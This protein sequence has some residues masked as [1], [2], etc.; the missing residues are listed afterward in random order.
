[1]NPAPTAE[2]PPAPRWST[3]Y[4][5][6]TD[7]AL[8]LPDLTGRVVLVAAFQMLCPA[9]V[10]RTIPQLELARSVF[11]AQDVAVIGLH[12]VF[13]HHRAM[14]AES[15]T[16][17]VHEYGITFPVGVDA[18][19]VDAEG[20]GDPVPLTMRRYGMRGTPTLLLIDRAGRLRRHV[21]GH[22]PDLR[23]GAEVAALVG[24]ARTANGGT[25][26]PVAAAGA[27]TATGVGSG[28]QRC[29]TEACAL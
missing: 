17:F 25:P 6:N 11:P 4:W 21:F 28:G 13:E 12:T 27:A 9:C 8:D 10:E 3:S 19:G 7:H 16:A 18:P 5:L 23:L 29:T 14:G 15:L 1:M 20:A 24:E 22:L 2:W 26:G